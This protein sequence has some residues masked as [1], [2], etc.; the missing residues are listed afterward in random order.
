[1]IDTGNSGYNITDH[2]DENLDAPFALHRRDF[3]H[4][5]GDRSDHPLL[6]GISL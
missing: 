5:H 2:L 4:H 6:R 1:M 3:V